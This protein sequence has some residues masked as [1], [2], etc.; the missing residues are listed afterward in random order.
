ML[1]DDLLPNARYRWIWRSVD[2]RLAPREACKW[3]VGVL[4][5]AARYDCE[6]ALGQQ[7][8]ATLARGEVPALKTL[9]AQFL[10][11]QHPPPLNA[12]QHALADYDQLLSAEVSHA[13]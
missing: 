6:Q 12:C 3:M 7:L 11:A 1:R 4:A 9:Q 8:V 5:L 13:R 10:P 2:R